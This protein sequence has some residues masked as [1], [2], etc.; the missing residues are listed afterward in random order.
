MKK[1]IVGMLLAG[2]EGKRLGLLTKHL[3]KPAV[4]FGGKYRIIDF[5]LSNCSNSK[6]HTVGVLTQY[7]PLELNRHIGIGKPWDMDRQ[8]DGLATLSPYTA[9]DGGSW[10]KGT[11]DAISQNIHYIDQYDPE[12]ILVISGDHIYQM[13]YRKMLEQ[14]KETGSEATISV[15]EV[16]WDEA[17][18]FGILNTREN[19]EIYEFDEKPANPKNN[20]ASMGIYIFTWASLRNYLIEDMKKEDSS[21]DFGKDI[22]PAMLND[23]HR[24]FAYRFDGYWK[25]VGTVKSYWEANMDLL[26][27]D[28]SLSLNNREWRTYSH[29]S[30]YP[31]HY[32]D[33]DGK[34]NNSLVTSGSWIS[35]SVNHSV[36]FERVDIGKGSVVEDSI[37][38]P[39]VSVGSDCT[40]KRAIIMEETVI[41]DETVIN[42]EQ[43]DE[44]VVINQQ[45]IADF[46]GVKGG[47]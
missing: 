35:G 36:L 7:S 42:G 23:D 28:L 10:Y 5:T 26:E 13:D 21:H 8:R 40:I 18:R 45:N 6:I 11:A 44:P 39:S 38:H 46:N 20:L 32:V 19:L 47:R 16:P 29:D 27:E 9:Q 12:Y 3:A 4:H 41:P 17:S 2:G 22:I 1:E 37:L 33:Q 30:H 25:D 24:M 15:M 34:V 31:P 43:Y 14:H